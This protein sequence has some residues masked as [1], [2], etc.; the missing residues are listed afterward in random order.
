MRIMFNHINVCNLCLNPKLYIVIKQVIEWNSKMSKIII[1]FASMTKWKHPLVVLVV[2]VV[3]V[4]LELVFRWMIQ[5]RNCDVYENIMEIDKLG[6]NFQSLFVMLL[7]CL[8]RKGPAPIDTNMIIP[9]SC[10]DF[11]KFLSKSFR[12]H[13]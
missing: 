4:V 10:L 2:A 7:V 13:L 3:V 12:T 1:R 8:C 11:E 9:N 5:M 6:T